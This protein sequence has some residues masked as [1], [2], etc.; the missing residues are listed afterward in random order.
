MILHQYDETPCPGMNCGSTDGKHSKECIAEHVAAAA[1]GDFVKWLPIERLTTKKC[2]D[3]W[4]VDA[5]GEDY[6]VPNAVFEHGRWVI[7]YHD[8]YGAQWLD[9]ECKVTH[10]M[11]QPAP[12]VPNK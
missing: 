5:D 12:P 9:E 1:G 7:G 4:V 2:V 3:I 11:D 8:E 6:R 10:Y